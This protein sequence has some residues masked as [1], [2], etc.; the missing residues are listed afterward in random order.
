MTHADGPHA[1][2]DELL[3]L[4]KK[5]L[6]DM[7]RAYHGDEVGNFNKEEFRYVIEQIMLGRQND[8]IFKDDAAPSA[9]MFYGWLADQEIDDAHEVRK[10]YKFARGV[11]THLLFE[12]MLWIAN[13]ESRDGIIETDP[14]D[15][16]KKKVRPNMVAVSRDRLR[17]DTIKYALRVMNPTVYRDDLPL[18]D[19]S[20]SEVQHKTVFIHEDG[21]YEDLKLGSA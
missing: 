15:K 17:V 18:E 9:S 14:K 16:S 10:S 4:P 7:L 5:Q 13:D 6:V 12:Q 21:E 20:A 2:R 8:D 11:R 3:K 1:S 19:Q